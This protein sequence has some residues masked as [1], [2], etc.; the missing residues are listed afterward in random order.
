M[1][2][3][4]IQNGQIGAKIKQSF[5]KSQLSLLS[6]ATGLPSQFYKLLLQEIEFVSAAEAGSVSRNTVLLFSGESIKLV[7]LTVCPEHRQV[8]I[9]SVEEREKQ[10]VVP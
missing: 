8:E 5:N 4:I 3:Q 6:E 2:I 9:I 10:V 7:V 1:E